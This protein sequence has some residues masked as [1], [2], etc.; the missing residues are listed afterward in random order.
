[1]HK[2]HIDHV[3]L[4]S[5]PDVEEAWICHNRE[6]CTSS[7]R[8]DIV[9]IGE[10]I[11]ADSDECFASIAGFAVEST[12]GFDIAIPDSCVEPFEHELE[13]DWIVVV[14]VNDEGVLLVNRGATRG[15]GGFSS[16]PFG[17]VPPNELS[18]PLRTRTLEDMLVGEV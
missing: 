18:K 8:R 16:A 9:L 6:M 7:K 14:D 3:V 17:A 11:D 13:M 4:A 10:R 12:L 5:S 15:C 1:M 2:Q